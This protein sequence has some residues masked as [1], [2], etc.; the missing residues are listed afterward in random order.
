MPQDDERVRSQP[1]QGIPTWQLPQGVTRATW[2]YFQAEHIAYDYDEFHAYNRLF[3]FDERVLL[4]HFDPGRSPDGSLVADLGCGSGR[5]LVTLARHGFRGLAVDLSDHM[6]DV[7][8]EKAAKEDLPIRT[9]RANLVELD[10][11]ADGSVDYAI[12]L[13]STLGMIQG[14]ENR[15]RCVAHTYRMLKPGGRYV[16]HVH[17]FWYNLY[18]PGG[19]RWLLQNLL[20]AIWSGDLEVGDKFFPYR[21]LPSMFL[22]VFRP[23]ELWHLL[24]CVGFRVVK[25]IPLAP[26]RYRPLT[27]PWFLSALR[28]NGWIVVCER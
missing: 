23:G 16:I 1:F 5:A 2:D 19:P 12:C 15:K 13:F 25:W 28:A 4:D 11:I 8:R 7:V 20:Q 24:R 9:L 10:E 27:A 17:N 22:H 3:E 14:S 21:G 26:Q 6:L 18:D